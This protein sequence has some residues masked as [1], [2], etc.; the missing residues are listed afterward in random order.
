[1]R[2]ALLLPTMLL[3]SCQGSGQ[4]PASCDTAAERLID[5]CDGFTG[6]AFRSLCEVDEFPLVSDRT[7]QC[8]TQL[9]VCEEAPLEACGYEDIHIVCSQTSDC[10]HPLLCDTELEECVRCLDDADCTTGRACLMGNCFDKDSEFYKV[11]SDF[12]REDGGVSDGGVDAG[13]DGG[14]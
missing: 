3:L 6:E 2:R 10:L 8:L 5:V 11:F 9:N 7:V 4:V 13:L 14:F 12:F 1:M